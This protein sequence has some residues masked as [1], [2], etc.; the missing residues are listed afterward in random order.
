MIYFPK[1][2]V[3]NAIA[4]AAELGVNLGV[5]Q[6]ALADEDRELIGRQ[7]QLAQVNVQIDKAVR[8]VLRSA[9]L[10]S[11]KPVL[12]R[13]FQAAKAQGRSDTALVR[14]ARAEARE[15]EA[16][17]KGEEPPEQKLDGV[18]TKALFD[19]AMLTARKS[20]SKTELAK[21]LKF[22]KYSKYFK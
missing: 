12:M 14:A 21:Y 22:K 18:L 5:A 1:Y 13:A 11:S 15:A 19:E 6:A 10:F 4:A 3:P 9:E 8:D 7:E 20:V 16:L 17:A 2:V